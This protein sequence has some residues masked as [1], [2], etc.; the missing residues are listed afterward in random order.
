MRL[1]K[2]ILVGVVGLLAGAIT[3]GAYIDR[4]NTKDQADL[5][6][7]PIGIIAAGGIGGFVLGYRRRSVR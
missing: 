3:A 7:I 5:D 2:G 1:L 4:H 6:I